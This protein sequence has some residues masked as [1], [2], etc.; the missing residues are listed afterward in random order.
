MKETLD[1]KSREIIELKM[2]LSEIE[3]E[4]KEND[5]YIESHLSHID[6]L[7]RQL[8]QIDDEFTEIENAKFSCQLIAKKLLTTNF[9]V[10]MGTA[11]VA[12]LAGSSSFF[13]LVL[14][15][16]GLSTIIT[17]P[18]YLKK[19]REQR[20]LIKQSKKNDL[21]Q[22]EQNFEGYLAREYAHLYS[23]GSRRESLLSEKDDVEKEINTVII[24]INSMME[25][26][27]ENIN[28][29]IDELDDR[30]IPHILTKELK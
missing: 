9:F 8:L 11:T 22:E 25:E 28:Q 27:E 17:T 23:L 14:V 15:T 18:I 20:F 24:D 16:T 13:N 19:T 5:S 29:A 4:L 2:A 12:S 6:F 26:A 21:I 1:K 10:A 7:E 3:N 30:D